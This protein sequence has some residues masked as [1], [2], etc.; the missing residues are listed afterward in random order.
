MGLLHLWCIVSDLCVLFAVLVK[1]C[2]IQCVMPLISFMS[3]YTSSYKHVL[4]GNP[5][6]QTI[7][8][9]Y[10]F[11]VVRYTFANCKHTGLPSR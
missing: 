5:V 9:A 3:L 8:A 4:L 6:E 7:M 10:C 2:A 1:S 11:D